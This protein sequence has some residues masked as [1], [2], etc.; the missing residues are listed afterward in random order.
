MVKELEPALKKEKVQE[1]CSLQ[2]YDNRSLKILCRI[3]RQNLC[4]EVLITGSRGS[5]VL[6]TGFVQ[7][8]NVAI[9]F[10]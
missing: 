6:A 7:L 4:I 3:R 2:T 5:R 10:I 8:K 9:G 1:Y